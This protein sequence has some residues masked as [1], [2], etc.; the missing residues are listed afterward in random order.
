MASWALHD[1]KCLNFKFATKRL[2]HLNLVNPKCLVL[3][4]AIH[5]VTSY[6]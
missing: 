6:T 1:V 3:M 2:A 5:T 4:Y